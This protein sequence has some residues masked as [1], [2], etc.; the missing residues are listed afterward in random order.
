M[1]VS[2]GLPASSWMP[3][4]LAGVLCALQTVLPQGTVRQQH[5]C[6]SFAYSIVCTHSCFSSE[7]EEVR[8]KEVPKQAKLEPEVKEKKI[9]ILI[10]AY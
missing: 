9:T 10:L 8:S 7:W 2:A 4:M 1:R 3:A 5:K 6:A